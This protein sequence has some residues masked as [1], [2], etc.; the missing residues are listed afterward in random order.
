MNTGELIARLKG[1]LKR[2]VRRIKQKT[3]KEQGAVLNPRAAVFNPSVM[4]LSMETH[5]QNLSGHNDIYGNQGQ[6]NI[7]KVNLPKL[8]L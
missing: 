4:E 7:F 8:Q 6:T 3:I 1:R 5:S 2:I